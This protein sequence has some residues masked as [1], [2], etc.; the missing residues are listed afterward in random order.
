MPG[1]VNF[2]ELPCMPTPLSLARTA[3]ITCAAGARWQHRQRGASLFAFVMAGALVT[4]FGLAILQF[5]MLYLTRQQFNHAVFMAT[6][7]G[8]VA[9]ANIETIQQ[10]YVRA[11]VPMHG[12]GESF[13]ELVASTVRARDA[14]VGSNDA[15]ENPQHGYARIVLENPT[16][17]SFSAWNSPLLQYTIGAG[18]RVIPHDRKAQHAAGVRTGSGQSLQDANLIRLRVIQGYRPVVPW[19]GWLYHQYLIRQDNLG[20]ATYTDLL[21]RG[22]IPLATTVTLQMQSDAIERLTVPHTGTTDCHVL[23]PT[24]TC[25]QPG[26]PPGKVRC[27]PACQP[28]G[29]CAMPELPKS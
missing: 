14:V 6:R 17:E 5:G 9:H 11:L 7:A 29:Q 23:H 21:S 18:S 1:T 2:L 27:D 25:L 15:G 20:D 8:A 10:A 16:R 13:D 24:D 22:L 26:C 19:M 4:L 28:P 12:G 3:R